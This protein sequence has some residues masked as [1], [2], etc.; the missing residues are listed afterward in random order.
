MYHFDLFCF[1]PGSLFTHSDNV[2][3]CGGET[4]KEYQLLVVPTPFSQG[5]AV[6]LLWPYAESN[7]GPIFTCE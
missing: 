1:F 7:D 2:A 4:D 3:W 6:G 5:A